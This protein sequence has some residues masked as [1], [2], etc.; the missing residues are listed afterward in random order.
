MLYYSIAKS[1]FL[2]GNKGKLLEAPIHLY[3]H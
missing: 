1:F 2:K 3:T